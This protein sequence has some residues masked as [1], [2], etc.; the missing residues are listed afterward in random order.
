MGVEHLQTA[1]NGFVVVLDQVGPDQWDTAT[2]CEGWNVTDLARHM[3]AG[4]SMS[5]AI[6]RGA[7]REEG[8]AIAQ[9]YQLGDSPRADVVTTAA[10]H[11]TAFSEPG[12]L[13]RTVQ[14]PRRDMPAADLL[15]FRIADYLLHTWD[16]ASGLGI[17]ANL[18]PEVVQVVWAA[19]SPMAETIGTS[20]AFG[21]GPSGSIGADA[22]LE[23]RLLDLTGRRPS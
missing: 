6:V 13:D 11:V 12:A 17:R 18:D 7:T 15:N 3:G 9:G 4:A 20:G 1:I 10:D 23:I 16:L 8:V 19:L 14:H 2:A 5:A 22:P 21:A